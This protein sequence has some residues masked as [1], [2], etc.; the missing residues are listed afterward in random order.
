LLKHND[1][2]QRQAYRILR[3]LLEPATEDS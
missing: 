3:E 1:A 2:K